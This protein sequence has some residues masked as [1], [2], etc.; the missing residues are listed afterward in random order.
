MAMIFKATDV[1]CNSWQ[2]LQQISLVLGISHLLPLATPVGP[3]EW[4]LPSG[5]SLL[6]V[7]AAAKM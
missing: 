6:R 7:H 1:F 4:Y 2:N 5:S 3:S